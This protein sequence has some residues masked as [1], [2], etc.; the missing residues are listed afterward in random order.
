MRSL[1]LSVDSAHPARY[2]FECDDL[3]PGLTRGSFGQAS[4]SWCLDSFSNMGVFRACSS[5]HEHNWLSQVYKQ[6][7]DSTT[8]PLI[9]ALPLTGISNSVVQLAVQ[10][11][12]LELVT[13]RCPGKIT[14]AKVA[15][16]FRRR[17]LELVSVKW[18]RLWHACK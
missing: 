7:P 13:N 16:T 8:A 6:D 3:V 17:Q 14:S 10:A 9:L 18:Q 11:D 15:L 1:H 12:S 5:N 4:T 2:F